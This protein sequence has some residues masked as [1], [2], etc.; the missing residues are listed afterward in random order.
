VFFGHS[1]GAL[2]AFE[3]ARRLAGQG[4]V[5]RHLVVSGRRAPSRRRAESVHTRDDAGLIAEVVALSGTDAA[6]LGDP[7]I[8]RM[9]LPAIRGDYRAVETHQHRDGPPLTCPITV[10][11]GDDDPRVS[12]DEAT[13]WKEHTTEGCDVRVLAGG[14]FF[15]VHHQQEI[16]DLLRAL[17]RP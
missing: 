8:L 13:A 17:L 4:I 2:L 1:M 7:E 10:L 9:V 3:V 5:P 11:T 6:I 15:L 16:N 12:L 14:H